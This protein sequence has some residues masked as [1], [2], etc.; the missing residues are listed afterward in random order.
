ML[1][2]NPHALTNRT[3]LDEAKWKMKADEAA[4]VRAFVDSHPESVFHYQVWV[5]GYCFCLLSSVVHHTG[6]LITMTCSSSSS[7]TISS[8][9]EVQSQSKPGVW[10]LVTS[11]MS[12]WAS[13]DFMQGL[14]GF[15]CKHHVRALQAEGLNEVTILLHLQLRVQEQ[16]RVQAQLRN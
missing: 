1:N 11:V 2:Y 15:L 10:H 8:A 9:N 5:S 13:C 12:S 4:G 3:P 14:K 6:N 16:L 7:S